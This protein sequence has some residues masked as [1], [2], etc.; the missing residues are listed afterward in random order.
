MH[1]K[2]PGFT[3]VEL[4]IVIVVIA[5]LAAISLVTY[6]GIQTRAKVSAVVTGLRDLEQGMKL[7]AIEKEFDAWPEDPILGGGTP[8]SELIVTYP[9]LAGYIQ[10]TPAVSGVESEE[11]FYDND[12]DSRTSCGDAFNGVN[13]VIRFVTDTAVAQGVDDVLDDGDIGCGK[14]RYASQRIFYSLS[15]DQSVEN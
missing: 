11:W 2:N 8:F 3:I 6:N 12:G 14:V 13:I 7:W 5:I 9:A 4:L 15:Y 1:K 10:N